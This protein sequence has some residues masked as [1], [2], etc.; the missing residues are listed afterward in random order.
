MAR[1]SA[2]LSCA[3][4]AAV[5]FVLYY[6]IL[7]NSFHYD[8]GHT[9][10]DNPWIRD[11]RN[12]PQFFV[13]SAVVSE[14]PQASN[15]RP[16]LMV[17]YSLNYALGGLNPWGFHLVNVL[18][19][20][21]TVLISFGL[22]RFC[23]GD[24][25][26]ALFGA[27]IFAIHPINSE[28]VNYITARSSVM[29]TLFMVLSVMTFHQFRQDQRD[30][31]VA[32]SWILYTLSLLSF[33]L[34]LFSKET[35][36]ILPG[37]ILATD[38]AF[39]SG[40]VRASYRRTFWLYLPWVILSLLFLW[41]RKE[42]FGPM[43]STGPAS[44]IESNPIGHFALSLLTGL[45]IV[46]R[47]VW[48]VLWPGE[49]TVD[50]HLVRA[51]SLW[52][53]S[54]LLSLVTIGAL[55]A[56][57]IWFWKR[58]RVISYSI[59]WFLISLLPVIY[60]PFFSNVALFQENR[61]YAAMIGPAIL[62]G[63]A[64]GRFLD[65]KTRS[66]NKFAGA[67]L[68]TLLLGFYVSTVL[69][70]NA[71]W[72]NQLTLWSDAV[73]KSPL[74]PEPHI[75]LAMLYRGDGN[76]DSA[77]R[78]VQEALRLAPEHGLALHMLGD[79]YSQQ[80]EK[81]KAVNAYLRSLQYAPGSWKT[82]TNLGGALY[83]LGRL[84]EAIQIYRRALVLNP[85]DWIAHRNL[86]ASYA[87]KEQLAMILKEYQEAAASKPDAF[88]NHYGQAVAHEMLNRI[89]AAE[90]AYKKSIELN[91][92]FVE[93]FIRLCQ[94]YV[95]AGNPVTASQYC[96]AV[97]KID[98]QNWAA[99]FTLGFIAEQKGDLSF[100]LKHYLDALKINPRDTGTYFN[101]GNVYRQTGQMEQAMVSYEASLK[102]NP[103]FLWARLNLAKLFEQNGRP[104]DAQEQYRQIVAR[105]KE[106]QD[107]TVK[108]MALENLKYL[109]RSQAVR[110]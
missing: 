107:D 84:D 26:A 86:I 38:L 19:H 6:N 60:L 10:V 94:L 61:S 102:L 4:L 9:V 58:Q 72:Q 21:L 69:Q 48:V 40:Q 47:Y 16:A 87:G 42:A 95:R 22:I 97:L 71:V 83:Q 34:A 74:S 12:L 46:A 55:L 81:E 39:H 27:L 108:L 8:D 91:P 2:I 64:F 31:R 93:G 79:L 89:E 36:V 104:V 78:E 50:H 54:L 18:L 103:D 106:G 80:G 52:E 110:K 49:L 67:F 68:V 96:E 30:T 82:Y 53:E 43:A 59:L 37:L 15:Y 29:S 90:I 98:S 88:I 7:D 51:A 17:T 65:L 23:L 57:V 56:G 45:K 76:M 62:A 32:R 5:T 33:P 75:S 100:A 73:Q 105:A 99:H 20:V 66:Y 41:L 14:S 28:S 44:A 85:N 92:G 77:F 11:M 109:E 35:A 25:R 101:L 24:I 1:K 13:S 70:R 3:F 63:W